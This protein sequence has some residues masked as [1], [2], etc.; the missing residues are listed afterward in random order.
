MKK[1]ILNKFFQSFPNLAGGFHRASRIVNEKRKG[2][3]D[4]PRAPLSENSPGRFTL[5]PH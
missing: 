1:E 5:D 2:A 3:P 4:L